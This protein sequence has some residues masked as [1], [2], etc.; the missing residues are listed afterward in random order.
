[1]PRFFLTKI[2]C[3]GEGDLSSGRRRPD[4]VEAAQVQ[5]PKPCQTRQV[6]YYYYPFG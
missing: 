6:S 1:M 5:V 3:G 2:E 4:V